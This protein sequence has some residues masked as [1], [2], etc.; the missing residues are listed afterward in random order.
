MRYFVIYDNGYSI[1]E[2]DKLSEAVAMYLDKFDAI[3]M[4]NKTGKIVWGTDS[5]RI[6][7]IKGEL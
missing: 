2:T 7:E 3:F 5:K 4:D 1:Y 6:K